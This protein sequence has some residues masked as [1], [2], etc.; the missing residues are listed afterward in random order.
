MI[1]VCG[2]LILQKYEDWKLTSEN[3]AIRPEHE[4]VV[5]KFSC[6]LMYS[7]RSTISLSMLPFR[8]KSAV[9]RRWIFD[10]EKSISFGNFPTGRRAVGIPASAGG[11]RHRLDTVILNW[12]GLGLFYKFNHKQIHSVIGKSKDIFPL[13][14]LSN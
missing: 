12:F 13:Q 4:L 5:K 14:F 1:K 6:L 9:F 11:D 8:L 10:F 2:I 7:T 3:I